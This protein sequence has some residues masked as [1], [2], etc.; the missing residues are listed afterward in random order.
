MLKH[1]NCNLKSTQSF[2]LLDP[3]THQPLVETELA[4]LI[5]NHFS[6]ITSEY[7]A[8]EEKGYHLKRTLRYLWCRQNQSLVD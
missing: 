1:F 4:D 2:T 3:E 8:L 5:N 7:L 6:A